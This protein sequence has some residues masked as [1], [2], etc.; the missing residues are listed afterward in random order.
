MSTSFPDI[1][2]LYFERIPMR[3]LPLFEG[4]RTLWEPLDRLE[5]FLSRELKPGNHRTVKGSV[6]IE[7]AVE[8]GEGTVIEHG[9][10]IIG[11]A[12]IGRNCTIRAGAYF[13]G[14]VIVGDRSVVGHATELKNAIL[15]EDVRAGHFNYIG[16]SVLGAAAALG[17]GAKIA[18]TRFD[19]QPIHFEGIDTKRRKFGVILGDRAQ[20]GVNV[21]L[22][23][24]M[25]VEKGAWI[26]NTDQRKSGAYRREDFRR[27]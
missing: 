19:N 15:F 14:N 4:A 9:A 3:I 7:G 24:G 18:N 27:S 22:G 26:P 12:I 6:H 13:R 11:P 17:A 10:V 21:M 16:D 1:F 5:A 20:L 8:I 25:A 2:R 23:P